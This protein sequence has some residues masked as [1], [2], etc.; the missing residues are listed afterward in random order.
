MDEIDNKFEL[1][2]TFEIRQLRRITRVHQRIEAAANECA[3]STTKHSLFAKQISFGFI[4]KGCLDHAG[5]SATDRLC[6]GQRRPLATATRVLVNRDQSRYS[7][8]V[9]EFAANHWPEPLRGDHHNIDI[10]SRNDRSIINRESVSEEKRLA[11]SEIRSNLFFVN[12][13]HLCI[14]QREKNDVP[15]AHRFSR[16]ENFEAISSRTSARF[17]STVKANND[18]DPTIAQVERMGASLCAKADHG[19]GLSF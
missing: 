13:R 3:G 19:A 12:G 5:A 2:Q 7:A 10:F 18:F 17:T 16:L 4:T 6:P 8:S 11:R 14:G 1:M 9:N 15:P